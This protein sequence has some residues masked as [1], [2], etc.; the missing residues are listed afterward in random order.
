MQQA[1]ERGAGGEEFLSM[2]M[3]LHAKREL[4]VPNQAL[5]IQS[6]R[7]RLDNDGQPE[8]K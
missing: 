2:L 5:S 7:F 6:C 3:G 1:I 4:L 8:D